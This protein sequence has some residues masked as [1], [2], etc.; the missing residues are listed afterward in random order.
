MDGL[1]ALRSRTG[2]DSSTDLNPLIQR[3]EGKL[4]AGYAGLIGRTARLRIHG[5][6]YLDQ[7]LAGGGPTIYSVWHGQSH[8]VYPVIRERMDV[9]RMVLMVVDDDRKHVLESFARGIGADPFPIGP[10]DQSI[11]GA[12]NLIR[13]V[14][15]MRDGR[16]SY[17]TPDGPD[18][19]ARVA[20]PGVAFLAARAQARV[21]PLGAFSPLAYRLRRWDRYSL[22]LPFA[23]IHI[24]IRSPMEIGPDEDSSEFLRHL[25]E[26][27]TLALTMAEQQPQSLRNV[28]PS[29]DPG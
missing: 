27:M 3:A 23:P 26:E 29:S 17:I 16:F 6:Q 11:S 10:Y 5:K 21:I 25:S 24:V 9:K 22:P 15:L 18:G 7:A 4:L 8:L 28:H 12:R 19:P 2:R 1:R 20:K 13:L 14:R